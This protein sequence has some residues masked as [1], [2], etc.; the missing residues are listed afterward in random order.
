MN[1]Y[2]PND[3]WGLENHVWVKDPIKVKDQTVDFNATD[4]EKFTD[5]GVRFHITANI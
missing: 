3:Q 5:N 2:F 1:Q 4:Y